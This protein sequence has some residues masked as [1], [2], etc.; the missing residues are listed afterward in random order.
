MTTLTFNTE[1]A[2][3]VK[4]I[5][6]AAEAVATLIRAQLIETQPTAP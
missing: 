6:I 4:A 2:R 1:D 3:T 5:A